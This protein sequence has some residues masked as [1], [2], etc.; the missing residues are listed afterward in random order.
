MDLRSLSC[1]IALA[2]EGHFGRAADRLHM[3]QPALSQRISALEADIGHPLFVRSPGPV[4][5]T[6]A[7]A[8]LLRRA[9]V[10]VANAAAARTDARATAN[11]ELGRLRVGFTQIVLY[12]RV[13]ELLAAFR[14]INPGIEL[15]LLEM[16]SPTQEMALAVGSIDVGLVHPPLAKPE[17]TFRQIGG[18]SLVLVLPADWPEAQHGAIR[19]SECRDMPF[20]MAPRRIGPTF[21]DGIIAACRVAGFSPKVVQ[22]AAPMSTLI[23]LVATGLGAGFIAEPLSVIKR[24]GVAFVRV[25]GELPALPVSVAW[26]ADNGSPA[27][28]RF[29][30]LAT[31]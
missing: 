1:A 19:L 10:A 8:A 24:P 18:I 6:E 26:R 31:V 15:E 21:Y 25:E 17:L 14:N 3:T 13:P 20:L 7:G 29:V 11:G 2:E 5:P 12:E 9:R 30:E 22:E 28:R 23:G 27:V 4:R 16:D